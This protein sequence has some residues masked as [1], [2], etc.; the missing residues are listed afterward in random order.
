MKGAELTCPPPRP[1]PERLGAASV[2]LK[3]EIAE[4]KRRLW[5]RMLPAILFLQRASP[6]SS[7]TC[8]SPGH[9]TATSQHGRGIVTIALTWSGPVI[10]CTIPNAIPIHTCQH[11]QHRPFHDTA[12][13][14]AY[15]VQVTGILSGIF[16]IT[17]YPMSVPGTSSRRRRT[18][19]GGYGGVSAVPPFG[20]MLCSCSK[21]RNPRRE[22]PKHFVPATFSPRY[23]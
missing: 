11:C 10:T 15:Q 12:D 13:R 21:N 14:R 23:D 8:V 5:E 22:S 20:C 7:R 1:Q 3:A 6:G 16:L 19:G 4:Q 9:R 17:P 18:T 2:M